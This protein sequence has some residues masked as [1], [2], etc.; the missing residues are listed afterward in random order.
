MSPPL[1][2]CVGEE[3][4][5]ETAS[6]RGGAGEAGEDTARSDGEAGDQGEDLQ[7]DAR[8]EDRSGARPHQDGSPCTSSNGR[9]TKVSL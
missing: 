6:Q 2:A 3:E 1:C 9:E 7:P 8:V 4:A 5:E